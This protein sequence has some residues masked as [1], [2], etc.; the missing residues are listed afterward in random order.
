MYRDIVVPLDPANIRGNVI[1][2]SD[3]SHTVTQT[4]SH[5]SVIRIPTRAHHALEGLL[6]PFQQVGLAFTN[7]SYRGCCY[8]GNLSV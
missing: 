1:V 6:V 7:A 5:T 8:R 3:A 2:N 4:S